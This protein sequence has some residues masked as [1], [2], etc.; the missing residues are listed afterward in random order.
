MEQKGGEVLGQGGY[1]CIISPP[2]K[3]KNHFKNIPYSIDK[4]FIS[5]IVEYDE[6]DDEEIMNEINIG[7]KLYKI[8]PNQ[9]FFSP[10]INGCHFYKQKSNDLDYLNRY[11]D[12]S[13]SDSYSNS[14]SDSDYDVLSQ[15]KCNIYKN[16]DYLNLISKNAGITFDEALNSDS[17][18]MLKFLKKNYILIFKHLCKGLDI[19]HKN[20][21]LHRDIK[22]ENIMINYNSIRNNSRINFID[23]GLSVECKTKYSNREL[24]DLT[25]Y[26]TN[27]YKPL[28]I[29]IINYMLEFLHKNRYYESKTFAKDVID[30]TY[31]E[32][33][34]YSENY[35]SE[36]HFVENGFKYEGRKLKK[37]VTNHKIGK[38]GNKNII[39]N[40]FEYLYRDYVNN[41]I[42]EKLVIDPKY[43]FK[44]DVFSLGLVFAEMLIVLDINNPKAFNLV[45]KMVA[46]YYWDRYTIKECLEDSLFTNTSI[47]SKKTRVK[48]NKKTYKK[49]QH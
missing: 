8:D 46:P 26:G 1:G 9:K 23:F 17:S 13:D 12:D 14:N 31:N 24:E 32:F 20:N 40:I 44:W 28:E 42:L 38:Y 49:S 39:K 29:I 47:T 10:I 19:I 37:N 18:D 35:Y 15:N 7:N 16:I 11:Y 36:L 25:Y 30:S 2:L 33:K 4:R 6:D 43:I 27:G 41:K 22:P 45:N 48:T 34:K 5:K 3:C 21:I